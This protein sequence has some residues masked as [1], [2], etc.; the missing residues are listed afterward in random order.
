M[1]GHAGRIQEAYQ[2]YL[3]SLS[4]NSEDDHSLKGIAWIALSHD[5][6]VDDAWDIIDF[7]LKKKQL[8]E[9]H[10]MLAEL[11]TVNNDQ[12][13]RVR[14]LRLFKSKVDHPA[15]RSMYSKYLAGVEAELGYARNCIAIAH[16]EVKNRPTPATY[17]LL[18][19]GYHRK[20]DHSKALQ[21]IREHVEDKTVEPESLY[22]MGMI[23]RANGFLGKG[24][25]LL[26]EASKGSF[27]LGPATAMAIE[28]ILE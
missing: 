12:E 6:K 28:N 25:E 7:L 1:Y 24:N 18:A 13:E 11:A 14:Q 19:W 27:E 4:F 23:Y 15:Y 20:G 16:Q 5:R 21:I 3:N 22:H 10:L 8:P 26:R 9:A 17:D 2:S